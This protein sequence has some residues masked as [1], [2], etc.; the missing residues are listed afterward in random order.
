MVTTRPLAL[1]FPA[2]TERLPEFAT[3][4]VAPSTRT[5]SSK[6]IFTRDGALAK[7]APSPGVVETNL[8]CA[9][10]GGA[11]AAAAK[12]AAAAASVRVHRVKVSSGVSWWRPNRFA[13]DASCPHLD[14]LR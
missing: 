14:S 6:R 9:Q 7:T 2:A 8:A 3:T 11:V 13:T 4:V 10:A 12:S 5:V 1:G